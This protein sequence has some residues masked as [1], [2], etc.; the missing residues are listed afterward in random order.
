MSEMEILFFR[1]SQLDLAIEHVSLIV[2][3]YLAGIRS[4]TMRAR[5]RARFLEIAFAL[6][7]FFA[8]RRE[9]LS[10]CR[11]VSHFTIVVIEYA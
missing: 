7:S 9:I 2:A 1:L 3:G 6:F 4:T 5:A 11:T 8:S 10:L